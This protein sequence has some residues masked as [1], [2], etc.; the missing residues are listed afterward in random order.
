MCGRD[1]VV[2]VVL[3]GRGV[4]G[5]VVVV[6]RSVELVGSGV[7][8][9]VVVVGRPVLVGQGAVVLLVGSGTDVPPVGSEVDV[10]V[11]LGV[12]GLVVV[13]VGA[14]AVGD[15]SAS[16]VMVTPPVASTPIDTAA[17]TSA[18]RERS[19]VGKRMEVLLVD[20]RRP[21][22]PTGRRAHA[23]SMRLAVDL[24]HCTEN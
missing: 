19:A 16:A 14:G 10:A 3:V 18:R 9:R 23:I 13:L 2:H 21:V 15:G 6:G 4:D 17:A 8:G 5:T 24:L 22:V 12:D 20:V 1:V 11:L 7:D